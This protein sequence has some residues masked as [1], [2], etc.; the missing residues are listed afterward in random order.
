MAS[1]F[2][3]AELGPVLARMSALNIALLLNAV[4][5][6]IVFE[7]VWWKTRRFRSPIPELNEL[8]PQFRRNDAPK[9]AKW[10][11]Y[12]GAVTLML[13]RFFMAVI[14]GIVLVI[15][16]RIIM[17]GH[18]AERPVNRCRSFFFKMWVQLGAYVFCAVTFTLFIRYRYLKPEDVGFYVEYLGSPDE[19]RRYQSSDVPEDPRVPKRGPGRSSTIVCN[20]VSFFEIVCMVASPLCPGFTPKAAIEGTPLVSSVANGL[21]SIY[22]K[23]QSSQKTRDAIVDDLIHRQEQVEV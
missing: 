20:H 10:K 3:V 4:L 22:I 15:G 6:L 5:G 1:E 7:W 16:C 18:N 19:Q 11:H 8:F 13:P 9:W 17:I 12:P 21:Q 14:I 23:R 2:E